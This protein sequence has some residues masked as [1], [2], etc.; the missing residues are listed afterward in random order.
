MDEKE[1]ESWLR[2]KEMR[3]TGVLPACQQRWMAVLT[4]WTW[5]DQCFDYFYSFVTPVVGKKYK[6]V[7]S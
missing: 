3:R 2:T 7:F 5:V 6:D 1:T 4:E